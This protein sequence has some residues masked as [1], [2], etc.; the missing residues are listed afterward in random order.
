MS[1]LIHFEKFITHVILMSSF[2]PNFINV[3]YRIHMK[4]DGMARYEWRH[5]GTQTKSLIDLFVIF[6]RFS[7][8]V[9]SFKFSQKVPSWPV[10]TLC[11]LFQLQLRHS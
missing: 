3:Y 2:A 9:Q 8:K 1:P 11:T 10:F 4:E 6:T 7:N 5:C